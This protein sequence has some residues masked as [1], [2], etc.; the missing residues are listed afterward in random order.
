MMEN[1]GRSVVIGAGPQGWQPQFAGG[2][3]GVRGFVVGPDGAE[4]P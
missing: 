3:R 2:A 4:A 1:T